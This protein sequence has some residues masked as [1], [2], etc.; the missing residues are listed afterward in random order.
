MILNCLKLLIIIHFRYF[1]PF[2]NCFLCYCV[3]KVSPTYV[4][5]KFNHKLYSLYGSTFFF[6]GRI[7]NALITKLYFNNIIRGCF[8]IR[9]TQIFFQE[10]KLR[11]VFVLSMQAAD[12]LPGGQFCP[13]LLQAGRFVTS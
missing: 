10:A 13:P 7:H 12:A 8:P 11:R 4:S 2:Y 9:F 6:V 1:F 3:T 5:L